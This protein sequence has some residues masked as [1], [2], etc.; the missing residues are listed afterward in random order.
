MERTDVDASSAIYYFLP[1][2]R[3]DK[4]A[5]FVRWLAGSAIEWDGPYAI[6]SRIC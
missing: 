4:A 1:P 6:E 3:H 5:A 2:T